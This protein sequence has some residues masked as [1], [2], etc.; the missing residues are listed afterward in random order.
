[1]DGYKN[2][3]LKTYVRIAKLVGSAELKQA[4]GFEGALN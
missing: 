4:A 2:P 3:A 1:M